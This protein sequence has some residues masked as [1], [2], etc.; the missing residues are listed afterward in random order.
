[1]DASVSCRLSLGSPPVTAMPAFMTRCVARTSR[2][3]AAVRPLMRQDDPPLVGLE[4][5]RRQQVAP[6][7]APIKVDLM[8]VHRCGVGAQRSIPQPGI[9]GSGRAVVVVARAGET[10]DVVGGAVDVA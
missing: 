9:E 4:P 2:P 3:G 10:D 8:H 5:E 6:G 1:M 7:A